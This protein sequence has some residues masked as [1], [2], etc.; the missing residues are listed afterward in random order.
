MY[1]PIAAGC[2]RDKSPNCVSNYR[3]DGWGSWLTGSH[4]SAGNRPAATNSAGIKCRTATTNRDTAGNFHTDSH[5]GAYP[6]PIADFDAYDCADY[7][8][9]T[10]ANNGT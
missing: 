10:F 5:Y 9:G 3:T 4:T 8:P 2:T 1:G 7:D 6:Y